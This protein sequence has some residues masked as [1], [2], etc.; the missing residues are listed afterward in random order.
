MNMRKKWL[1]VI[2]F[3]V[4]AVKL[5][6][7]GEVMAAAKE[8]E[9]RQEK[10]PTYK[11]GE[12]KKWE[13]TV[14]NNTEKELKNITVSPDLGD[15]VQ[16]WPFQTDYQKYES[17]IKALGAGQE[18]KISFNLTQRDDVG[19]TR[20][21]ILFEVS[22]DGLE[23]E[24][25]KL[26]VNTTAKPQE[27]AGTQP[28]YDQ[29]SGGSVSNNDAAYS[30]SDKTG[31]TSVPRVIVT[32][33]STDPGEVRAGKDFTLTI[34]LKNTSKSTRVK[35]MFFDLTSPTEGNDEQTMAPA[36]L[37]TSGSS[38]VYLEGI[39]ANGTASISI[40]LNAKADLL[41]K[42][43]SIELV[44]KY[45]DAAGGQIDASS[46]ISIPVKQDARFEFSDFEINPGAISVGEEANVMCSLYNLGRIK[47]YNVKVRFEGSCIEKEE[48]FLGNIDSGA[49]GSID[50]MLEGSK[51]TDGAQKV[52]MTLSYEDESGNTFE[53]ERELQLEVTEAVSEG[54]MDIEEMEEEG[55]GF[56][57]VLVLI[58]VA[59]VIVA[60]VLVIKRKKKKQILNE[61]EEL[62]YELDGPSEDERR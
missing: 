12:T 18:Q 14:R 42:P 46:G 39:K 59:V 60:A 43:Y 51:V 26:Y 19:T 5:F 40:Q 58:L 34:H 35:N 37:P 29:N 31:T 15:D 45:E 41:Q 1:A 8:V 20:Y 47:L 44:M 24:E 62:L 25:Q 10:V 55:K 7:P 50:A 21:T 9:I 17:K 22:A 36:F 3:A 38:S 11:A 61:E 56:P 27:P 53:V 4:M 33:F 13:I 30:G 16:A 23:T 32:G 48:I 57:T 6:V 54:D 49:T 28:D 2:L 52:T